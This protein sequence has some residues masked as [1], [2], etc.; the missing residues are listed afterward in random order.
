MEYQYETSWRKIENIIYITKKIRKEIKHLHL[1]IND[2]SFHVYD[3]IKP[4]DRSKTNLNQ[5]IPLLN[6]TNIK[7]TSFI[8]RQFFK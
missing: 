4:K 5:T 3:L 7:Q 2:T 1:Q 8:L 6:Y